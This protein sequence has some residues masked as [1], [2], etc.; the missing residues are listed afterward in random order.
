MRHVQHSGQ[1]LAVGKRPVL[2]ARLKQQGERGEL[3]G[4][5]VY[6]NARQVVAKDA[7]HRF[8]ALITRPNVHLIQQVESLKQYMT[9]AA[10]RVEQGQVLQFPVAEDCILLCRFCGSDE[11][12]HGVFKRR[13][14]LVVQVD[15]P[16]GV[17]HHVF[18]YP[19]RREYLRCR[20]NV[21]RLHL[22]TFS[23]FP[24]YL[25]LALSVVELIEPAQ[26][27]RRLVVLVGDERRVVEH[28]QEAV[29]LQYVARQ[30]QLRIVD[31]RSEAALDDRSGVAEGDDQQGELLV[32]LSRVANDAHKPQ[33]LRLA[34]P[35]KP[36]LSCL[37]HYVRNADVGVV[38]REG[39][40][41]QAVLLQYENRHQAVEPRVSS[42]FVHSF[43]PALLDVA[44]KGSPQIEE[45]CLAHFSAEKGATLHQS[46][47][48][49]RLALRVEAQFCELFLYAF[50]YLR[51]CLDG[52][53]L[54]CAGVHSLTSFV[55]S[56]Y[57]YLSLSQALS[58]ERA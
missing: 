42:F 58:R 51:A 47:P 55:I 4:A 53:S 1:H 56:Q 46:W 57:I 27:F 45:R 34:H 50:L 9:R 8:S 38:E 49:F 5:G 3:F 36:A 54:K 15:T 21:I 48:V 13:A 20:R 30:Q 6:V 39:V 29:T 11:I 12:V 18:H 28:I 17:L 52:K 44:V 24:V 25:V 14:G 43:K 23:Q 22:L 19:V 41:C 33:L 10:G 26:Q 32:C 7:L 35:G 31:S 2:L 37:A 16:E 40:A